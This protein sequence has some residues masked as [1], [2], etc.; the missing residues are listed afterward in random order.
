LCRAAS[1]TG[2]AIDNEKGELR[3]M[4]QLQVECANSL[5]L[6]RRTVTFHRTLRPLD[7][8]AHQVKWC[9]RN[10]LPDTPKPP[11]PGSKEDLEPHT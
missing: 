4:D 10:A 11:C 1:G 6:L 5:C 8:S 2:L 7:K 9:A 3:D